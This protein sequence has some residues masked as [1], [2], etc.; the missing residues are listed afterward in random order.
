MYLIVG[1]AG[2]LGL[3]TAQALALDGHDVVITTRRRSDPMAQQVAVQSDGR[4]TL[5]VVD[6]NNHH[7]VYR[8]MSQYDFQT[9]AHT[10]TN[11][12][13]AQGR[14]A[15]FTSYNMLFNTLE[16]AAA[17]GVSRFVL[18]S[19]Q[20]VYRGTPGPW[21]ESAAFP[22]DATEN[23]GEMLKFVPD[24]EIAFKRVL[25]MVALDYGT[26][27][28][29]WD[30]APHSARASTSAPMETAVVR[31][32]T[33]CGP[34]YTSMYNP[35]ACLAHALAKG[36]ASMPANR[37]LR[38]VN[39][40]AYVRDNADGLKT[41]L[42]AKSLPNRIYNVSSGVRVTGRQIAESAHRIDPAGA[43]RLGLDPE[44]QAEGSTDE[45]FDL[46]RMAQDF[47]WHP[48]YPTID[49]VLDDYLGWLRHHDF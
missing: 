31:F 11:H 5:E 47:G 38:P 14:S 17:F 8:L 26:P 9:V 3:N 24:F 4:I 2:F 43:E 45:Y 49:A 34:L 44:N 28:S 48:R 33:Q 39:D 41:V 16:A 7:E 29:V 15:N 20:V 1:G 23:R 27:V 40:I 46:T 18:A 22:P 21:V 13:F 10:A 30:R 35:T 6:L 25:E 36:H 37:T 42:A 19:S 32:A 12:M